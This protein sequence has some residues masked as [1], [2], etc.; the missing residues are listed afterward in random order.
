MGKKNISLIVLGNTMDSSGILNHISRLRAEKAAEIY[1]SKNAKNIITSG[2]AYRKDINISLAESIKNFLVNECF[3]PHEN[4]I[5]EVNSRDTVGD[6]VFSKLNIIKKLKISHLIVV[7]SDFHLNRVKEIFKFVYGNKYN[8]EVLG[9]G[10]KATIEQLN[11]EKISIKNFKDTFQGLTAKN[12]E[13][14]YLHM[15]KFHPLYSENA[16]V[17]FKMKEINFP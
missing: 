3:V 2:W 11:K 7:T 14:I 10:E 15:K 6:A 8:I 16:E 5:P 9:T 17:K 13:S 1:F 12:I 4:V